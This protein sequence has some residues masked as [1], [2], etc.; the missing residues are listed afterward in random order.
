F[1]RESGATDAVAAICA[2][3]LFMNC[4][5]PLG[6]GGSVSSVPSCKMDWKNR[7]ASRPIRQRLNFNTG[8]HD[9][10]ADRAEPQDARR[11]IGHQGRVLQCAGHLVR[12]GDLLAV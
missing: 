9:T 10:C 8:E 5:T 7:A 2:T 3:N 12:P 4:F 11:V 1:P 6:R